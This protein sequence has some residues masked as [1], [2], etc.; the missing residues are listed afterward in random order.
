MR[1]W[2]GR[3][4]VSLL[5]STQRLH[6]EG[7]SMGAPLSVMFVLAAMTI[8]LHDVLV[9][10]VTWKLIAHPA[11]R[12]ER[13]GWRGKGKQWLMIENNHTSKLFEKRAA[14]KYYRCL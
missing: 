2:E 6:L 3:L 12:G 10:T 7:L 5:D 11:G 14:V 13:E 4:Q 8:T 9:T 1:G